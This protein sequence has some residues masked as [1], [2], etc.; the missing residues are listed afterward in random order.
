MW[1]APLYA[2]QVLTVNPKGTMYSEDHEY[3]MRHYG[4]DR[5]TASAYLIALRA[6]RN[7][8]RPIET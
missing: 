4:L 7:L 6:R 1:K 3:V 2:L 5:H 8:Q